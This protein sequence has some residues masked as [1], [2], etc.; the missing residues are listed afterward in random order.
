MTARGFA[1]LWS[2][3]PAWDGN[4]TAMM[5]MAGGRGAM[6]RRLSTPVDARARRTALFAEL[7]VDGALR[8]SSP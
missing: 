3:D 6:K 7:R 8:L 1:V 5:G 4:Q 2:A